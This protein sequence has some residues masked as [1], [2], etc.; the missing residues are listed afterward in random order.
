MLYNSSKNR[1]LLSEPGSPKNY[2]QIGAS[3]K[4]LGELYDF[5][6]SG[7]GKSSSVFAL[8]DPNDEEPEQVIKICNYHSTL[9]GSNYEKKR[10]RFD[11]EIRA[12]LMA[13]RA[14]INDFLLKIQ[15]HDSIN[16]DG[17]TFRYYVMEKADSDLTNYLSENRLS[18]QQKI[19]ICNNL[20]RALGALHSIGIYHRDLKPDNIFFIGDQWKIGDLGFIGFREKDFEI[21]GKTERIGPTGL[22]SPEA[23]N[24]TFANRENP[25]FEIDYKIDDMSDIFQL[26]KLF[27]YIFQG[28]LPTGLVAFE[29]FKIG[30]KKIF[31]NIITPMLQYA[32]S[33]RPKIPELE[34]A[35]APILREF[36]IA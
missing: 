3:D 32:K 27:W 2:I 12:L 11:R 5:A 6:G 18:L 25:E 17:H 28:D 14:G 35:F 36:A 21:D 22:M 31:D 29:D 26:G 33:R 30:N 4:L 34:G 20:L 19:V 15:H 9:V 7:K 23:I 24:K 1:F 13:S 16:V 10:L 8:L